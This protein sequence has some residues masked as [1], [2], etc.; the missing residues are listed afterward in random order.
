MMMLEV[1]LSSIVEPLP[2]IRDVTHIPR[3]PE[4]VSLPMSLGFLG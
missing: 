1:R 3:R 4:G 2:A